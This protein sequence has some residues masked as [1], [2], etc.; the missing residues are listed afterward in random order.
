MIH[1]S[2]CGVANNNNTTRR[3][4]CLPVDC[5]IFVLADAQWKIVKCLISIKI[6]MKLDVF[7]ILGIS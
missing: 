2:V 7:I 3:E 4:F 5:E 6:C 1:L